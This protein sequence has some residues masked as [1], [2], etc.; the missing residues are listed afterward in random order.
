[1][2]QRVL[3]K[4]R[5]EN[6]PADPREAASA[7][8]WVTRFGEEVK[9]SSV[10]LDATIA[11]APM[12]LGELARLKPG[13]VIEVPESAPGRARLSVKDKP[14]FVCEFGR[15]GQNYTVRIKQPFDGNQDLMEGIL[16][17]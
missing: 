10:V 2:P 8:A 4:H 1:M 12:T 6:M 9:R 15:L 11:L 14:L 5:A 3:L 7:A 17:G 16:A 13:Q